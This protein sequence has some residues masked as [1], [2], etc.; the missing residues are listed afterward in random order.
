MNKISPSR[1]RILFSQLSLSL[2]EFIEEIDKHSLHNIV[3]GTWS[4][5]DVLC[6]IVYWH[7]YYA[8]QYD[9][10]AKGQKPFIF[11]SRGGSTRNQDGVNSLKPKSKK[12]LIMLLKKSNASLYQSIVIKEIPSMSYTNRR[13]Y[14]SDE[15]LEVVIGHIKRHTDQVR[16]EKNKIHIMS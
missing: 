7:T 4:V 1:Y 9:A 6:H 14:T 15:F 10:L 8:N 13:H 12:D 5:K 16:R 2:E 3:S 11:S